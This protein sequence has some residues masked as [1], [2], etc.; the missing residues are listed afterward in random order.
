M[1]SV[2]V[3]KISSR[4]AEQRVT[5]KGE[6]TEMAEE[7]KEWRWSQR[8]VPSEHDIRRMKKK[9]RKDHT[10]TVWV[11]L[12]AVFFMFGLIVGYSL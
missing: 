1:R 7:F 8:N 10:I 11:L 3:W 9:Q 4:F 2:A 5:R 12:N 6:A